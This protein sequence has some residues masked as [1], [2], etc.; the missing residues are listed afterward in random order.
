[1][2]AGA[3]AE[4]VPSRTP[5]SVAE[6]PLLLVSDRRINKKARTAEENDCRGRPSEGR[7]EAPTLETTSA[8]RTAH[9]L[10]VR[11]VVVGGGVE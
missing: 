6:K 9:E 7:D 8:R 5:P 1:M 3:V 10:E 4:I 11:F 2:T